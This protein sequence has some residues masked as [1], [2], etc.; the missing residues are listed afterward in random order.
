MRTNQLK[1]IYFR[2]PIILKLLLAIFIIM[3]SFG[4]IIHLLEPDQFPTFFDGIWWAFQTGATVGYG[5]YVP[6]SIK[7]KVT[8]IL[9]ILTGGGLLAFYITSLSKTTVKHEQNFASGKLTFKGHDH[10]IIIGWNERTRQLIRLTLEHRPDLPIIL[11][12]RTLRELPYQHYPVHF[13]HGDPTE[14]DTLTKANIKRASKVLITADIS[15]KER[16]ADNATIITTVAIRGNNRDVP[17]V[18]EI[19]SK[20]QIE[21]ALRA[22]A[23]TIIRSNDFM[24][25]LFFHELSH[26]KTATPFEDILQI[27]SKQQ[28]AHTKLPSELEEKSFFEIGRAHV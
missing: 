12:D 11:V 21:N 17:I 1:Q 25:A 6:L 23:T 26:E 7:G 3:F 19:L 13:V 8:G 10:L 18:A 4:I 16:Q 27:L 15:S 28:F 20:I 9:L 22:G 14:D 24:S 2:T 5:D